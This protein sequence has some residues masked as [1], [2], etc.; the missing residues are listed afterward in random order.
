MSK[1]VSMSLIVNSEDMSESEF[2]EPA[3][4]SELGCTIVFYNLSRFKFP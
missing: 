4:V 3:F 1:N 2:R